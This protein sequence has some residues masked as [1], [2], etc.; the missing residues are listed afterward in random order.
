VLGLPDCLLRANPK[1]AR[2]TVGANGASM[3]PAVTERSSVRAS[4]WLQRIARDW[5]MT[6]G[7]VIA[8]LM[9][10]THPTWKLESA[11]YNPLNRSHQKPLSW[12]K[13]AAK[14]IFH[15][16]TN[17]AWARRERVS[18]EDGVSGPSMVN[19]AMEVSRGSE[20]VTIPHRPMEETRVKGPLRRPQL[21]RL[22]RATIKKVL[23]VEVV[24]PECFRH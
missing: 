16:F 9:N 10:V 20:F 19:A 22:I 15:R 13:N 4:V 5:R 3:V 8:G 17:S 24:R 11:T 21:V 7:I 23:M 12:R 6:C 2:T 1:I 14:R 18:M